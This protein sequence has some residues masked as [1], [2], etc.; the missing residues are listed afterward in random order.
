MNAL[1]YPETICLD[2][3]ELKYLL[4]LYDKIFFLPIDNQLNPGHINLS[5][6]FSINDTILTGAFKS[7]RDSHYAIMYSSEPS[8][9]DERM[10]R[11]MYLYDEL[12]AKEIV[13]G[14]KDEEFAKSN[15]WHPLKVAVDTDMKDSEFL[16]VCKRHQNKKLFA[17]KLDGKIKGGGLQIRP[18]TFKKELFIPSICS[19]R[20]NTTLFIAGRDNLFPV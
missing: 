6:R 12:E 11:L 16:S 4:L 1:Y 13:I 20:I 8:V 14:L 17:A 10:K 3:I 7:K 18:P 5:K 15:Q 19:E 2:D 9:W